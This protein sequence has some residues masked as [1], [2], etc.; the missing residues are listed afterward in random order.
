M[1]VSPKIPEGSYYLIEKREQGNKDIFLEEKLVNEEYAIIFDRAM[2]FKIT[3]SL[4]AKLG[5]RATSGQLLSEEI[6]FSDSRD[7]YFVLKDKKSRSVKFKV[8]KKSALINEK[9]PIVWIFCLELVTIDIFERIG[10]T[11]I[12]IA[13]SDLCLFNLNEKYKE[14]LNKKNDKDSQLSDGIVHEQVKSEITGSWYGF[15]C[16]STVKQKEY[17]FVERILI[18]TFNHD[19][20]LTI[21]IGNNMTDFDM[22]GV[23]SKTY[24]LK[25]TVEDNLVRY[26]NVEMTLKFMG[27]I[28]ERTDGVVLFRIPNE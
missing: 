14:Y 19:K 7:I 17:I 12:L 10:K 11:Y 21:K 8:Y 3:H 28:I 16:N 27:E 1:R 9:E 23:Y 20:T 15:Y 5:L 2:N 26:G 6:L 24:N 13:K 18:Y 4:M 25:Y 22:F